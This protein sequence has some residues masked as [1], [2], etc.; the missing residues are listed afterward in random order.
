MANYGTYPHSSAIVAFFDF[1]KGTWMESM[2]VE[3]VTSSAACCCFASWRRGENEQGDC[4]S[5]KHR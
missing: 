4:A 5:Y 2:N 3:T 1:H